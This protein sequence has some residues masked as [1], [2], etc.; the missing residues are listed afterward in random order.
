MGT[1][2]TIE[3]L[4]ASIIDL[5]EFSVYEFDMPDINK[6]VIGFDSRIDADGGYV[7]IKPWYEGGDRTNVLI[8]DTNR[9]TAE[10]VDTRF[11]I[12]DAQVIFVEG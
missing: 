7:M 8:Y 3:N 2:P 4:A 10:I 12:V 9:E 1:T 11:H 5:D 6:E